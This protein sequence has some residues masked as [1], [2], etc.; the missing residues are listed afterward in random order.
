MQLSSIG[1]SPQNP[2]AQ[3]YQVLEKP[4]ADL[5]IIRQPPE[6]SEVFLSI[7]TFLSCLFH[8]YLARRY[9]VR[10]SDVA[11]KELQKEG[12]LISNPTK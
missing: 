10:A 9:Q 7:L 2:K 8:C 12:V 3:K 5:T 6:M 4:V 11:A 1:S